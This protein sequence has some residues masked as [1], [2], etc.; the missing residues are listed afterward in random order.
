MARFD[1]RLCDALRGKVVVEVR[2]VQGFLRDLRSFQE[3]RKSNNLF[4]ARK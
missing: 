4:L 2:G 1:R 3:L